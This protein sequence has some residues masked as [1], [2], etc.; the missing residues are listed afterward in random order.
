MYLHERL[1]GRHRVRVVPGVSALTAVAAAAGMPLA[2]RD[3]ALAVVPAILPEDALARRFETGDATAIVKV[4]RHLDK[5]RRALKLTGRERGALYVERATMEAERAAPLEEVEAAPYFSMILVPE[6]GVGRPASAALEP[7]PGRGPGGPGTGGS[8][9]GPAP[10]PPPARRQRPWS[11]RVR[12]RGGLFRRRSP[13]SLPVPGRHA[14]RRRHGGGHH[15]PR[16]GPGDRGQGEPG[17][18]W[19][20]WPRTAVRPCPCSAATTGPTGWPAP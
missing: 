1:A 17:P 16:P 8:G 2:S 14:H 5:V 12:R 7:P 10:R 6:G 4:G 11:G 15:H 13:S 18:R 20:P 19:S 3:Q 9:T